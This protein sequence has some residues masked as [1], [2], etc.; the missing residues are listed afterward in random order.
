MNSKQQNKRGNVVL[1]MYY[2]PLGFLAKSHYAV[3]IFL[4]YARC[5]AHLIFL[6]FM[7]NT[8]IKYR[9]KIMK[10]LCNFSLTSSP[11][12][13]FSFLLEFRSKTV[14]ISILPSDW[15]SMFH[16]HKNNR[17]NDSWMSFHLKVLT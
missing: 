15:I 16:I 17:Q 1:H 12:D 7:T 6:D 3:L 4:T 11:L 9:V 14:S 2:L 8:N 10:P 13:Q 5:P